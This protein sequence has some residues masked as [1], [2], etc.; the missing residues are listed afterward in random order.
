MDDLRITL[1]Q[2]PL[3]WKT[4]QANHSM[5]EEKITDV[6]TDLI[7]LPEMFTTGFTMD[8]EEVAEPENFTTYRWMKQMAARTNAVITGSC[9]IRQGKQFYNRLLW[10]E[11]SGHI[12]H[13]DKRHLFRM[14]GEHS[15]YTAGTQKLICEL[16]G[17]KIAPF[18][19]YDLRFPV[20]IRNT[21]T[22]GFE[23]DLAL[24]VANWPAPRANAWDLLLKARAVENSSYVAG[25]NRIGEDGNGVHYLGESQ[26]VD[27]RGK[28]ILQMKGEEDVATIWLSKSGLYDYRKKFPVQ[29]DADS[30]KI[31]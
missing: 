8:A 25:V 7:V 21:Y 27:P 12:L 29:E 11:P 3:Y 19:C 26:V 1:V 17:W 9:V 14:A 22:N 30:F 10:V 28:E 5:L 16:K 6:K 23:Y 31:E 4:P 20:W 18:I 24:F 15:H 13:Y 2:I